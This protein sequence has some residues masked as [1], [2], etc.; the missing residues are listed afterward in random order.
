MDALLHAGVE[1]PNL[2]WVGIAGVVSF[3]IGTGFGAFV[4]EPKLETDDR[5]EGEA[6]TR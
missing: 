4:L 1:H 5:A 3:A 6:T 2:V